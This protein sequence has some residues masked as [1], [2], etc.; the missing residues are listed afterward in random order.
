MTLTTEQ[1]RSLVD[2]IATTA[3]LEVLVELQRLARREHLF[4]PGGGFLELLLA[5]RHDTLTRARAR[6]PRDAGR[7]AAGAVPRGKGAIARSR[8]ACLVA[9]H[10]VER[11][12]LT[13]ELSALLLEDSTAAWIE[14][15]HSRAIRDELCLQSRQNVAR[16]CA[17]RFWWRIRSV[18]SRDGRAIA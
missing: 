8:A 7:E 1:S 3:S 16:L 17:R 18:A 15:Q 6:A 11:A 13:A 9:L 2:A 4:D 14:T 10:S 5:V 12:R